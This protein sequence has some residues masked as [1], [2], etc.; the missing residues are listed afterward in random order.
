MRSES[1]SDEDDGTVQIGDV[2]QWMGKG[3]RLSAWMRMSEM[4]SEVIVSGGYKE[5]VG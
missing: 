4:G 3:V 1:V 5:W 2:S